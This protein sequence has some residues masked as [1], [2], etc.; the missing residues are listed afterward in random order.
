[1]V[2][3][4]LVLVVEDAAEIRDL[5]VQVL[6]G[7]GYR[8]ATAADGAAGLAA[9][10]ADPPALVL[11]DLVMP[12]LDGAEL[13]RRLRADQRT[14]A[15]PVLVMT[16]LAPQLAAAS[17]AG[18]PHDGLLA[19]PFDLDRLFAAVAALCPLSALQPVVG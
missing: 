11:T 4:P 16:A 2:D 5:M 17:L 8:V 19:K 13:C 18:C 7:E 3:E 12:G 14:R 10:L 6:E 9:A 1:M 15:V